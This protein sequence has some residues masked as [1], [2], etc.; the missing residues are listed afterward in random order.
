VRASVKFPDIKRPGVTLIEVVG[1][2]RPGLL[3]DL[4]NCLHDLGLD[5]LSAHI[6]VVGEKAIDA[7]YVKGELREKEA[8]KPVHKAMRAVLEAGAAKKAA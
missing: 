6:E 3:F 7:F 4:A 1:R 5:L 2:D 8:Q